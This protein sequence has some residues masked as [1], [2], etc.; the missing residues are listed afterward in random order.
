MGLECDR[1]FVKI[2]D[3]YVSMDKNILSLAWFL[4]IRTRPF[5][6]HFTAYNKFLRILP[7]RFIKLLRIINIIKNLIFIKY[8][9]MYMYKDNH[10]FVES[11]YDGHILVK[12]SNGNKIF[13]LQEKTVVTQYKVEFKKE[14]FTKIATNL[15]GIGNYYISPN[16]KQINSDEKSISEEYINL[17]KADRFYPITSYF[18]N[19][20]LPIWERN[21]ELF[22]I[23]KIMLK[24]YLLDQERFIIT[25]INYLKKE[26]Y[27]RECLVNIQRYVEGLR[28]KLSLDYTNNIKYIYLTLTHG[29]LHAWNILLNKKKSILIDWDTQKERSLYHDFY[30]MYYHNIFERTSVNHKSFKLSLNKNI[31]KTRK[32]VKKKINESEQDISLNKELYRML[33]YLEYIYLD[34]E[35]RVE[36]QTNNNSIQKCLFKINNCIRVFKETDEELEN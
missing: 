20:I 25:R 6:L 24:D 11:S 5:N 36:I 19:V 7:G 18:D 16:I 17:Y 27:D 13:N 10:E 26:G 8:M 30:Y 3:M 14:L 9:Y 4:L 22:P 15:K 34:F 29:D 31:N 28:E 12:T 2:Q 35:N 21:I 32:N 1:S 23:K 33:F